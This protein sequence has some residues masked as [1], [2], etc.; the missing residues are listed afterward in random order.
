MLSYFQVATEENIFVKRQ[1]IKLISDISLKKTS[2]IIISRPTYLETVA[3][4]ACGGENR[5][6]V[7]MQQEKP[8]SNLY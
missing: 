5:L 8:L 4:S 6:Q 2:E 7:I 1:D 3:V